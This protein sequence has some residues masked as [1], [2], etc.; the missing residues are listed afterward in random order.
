LVFSLALLAAGCHKTFH[1]SVTQPNPLKQ[2]TET[3]RVSQ[4]VIIVTGDMELS[5]PVP[6]SNGAGRAQLYR[7]KRYP[8]RN[9]AS[10][11]VVSRDRLRFH[12][13]IEHKWEEYAN[14]KS[15]NAYLVDDQGHK[16]RPEAVEQKGPM[17]VVHMWDRERRTVG[18]QYKGGYGAITSMRDDAYM[19]R[20]TLG[21]LSVFRGKGDLVFYSRD[22][23]SPKIKSL[24]LVVERRGLAFSWTW[25]FEDNKRVEHTARR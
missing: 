5:M 11:T 17:H 23:F 3:L 25:R 12:L 6:T 21:S 2:P 18:R 14:L 10:F 20:Q 15:W 7:N 16:Y 13:Q 8:L 24:T 9:V 19:N 22:I 4:K 1:G